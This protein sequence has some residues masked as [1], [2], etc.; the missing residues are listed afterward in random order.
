MARYVISQFTMPDGNVMELKDRVAR[1]ATIGGVHIL[2]ITTTTITDE[3]TNPVVVVDGVE[4]TARNGDM[5]VKD[6]LEFLYTEID[7]KWHEVGNTASLGALA[8]KDYAAGMYTPG[9]TISPVTFTGTDVAYTPQGSISKPDIN[10]SAD[11]IGS[12]AVTPGTPA[13][14]TMPTMNFTYDQ[15]TEHV[16]VGWTAGSFTPNTPTSVDLPSIGQISA[17]LA[18]APVFTGQ[19]ATIPVAGTVS[20]PTFTGTRA[21]IVVE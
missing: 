11:I 8:M 5:V 3:S 2:G 20:Q 7:G 14:A 10:I 21:T 15:E 17:E 13:S 9:G 12:G 19:Q 1:Q 18:S 16:T 4:V 6:D